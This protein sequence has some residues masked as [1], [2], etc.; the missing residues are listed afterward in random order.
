V[1]PSNRPIPSTFRRKE[2]DLLRSHFLSE[3]ETLLPPETKPEM[4]LIRRSRPGTHRSCQ[5]E[6]T[7]VST[8]TLATSDKHNLRFQKKRLA[9][10]GTEKKHQCNATLVQLLQLMVS[11]SSPSMAM[12]RT[13]LSHLALGGS[14]PEFAAP[15]ILLPVL[16]LK[17]NTSTL[18][19][20]T[21]ADL[22][23]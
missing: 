23:R 4:D 16:N 15:S 14:S 3:I 11:Q 10:I 21:N 22:R 2:T 19:Q 12:A 18:C 7:A 13:V 6:M 20:K 9:F 5:H 17:T 1:L 8:K